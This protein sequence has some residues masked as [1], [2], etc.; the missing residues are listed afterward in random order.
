MVKDAAKPAA[1]GGV[2]KFDIPHRVRAVYGRQL[3]I[4]VKRRSLRLGISHL[5]LNG[6]CG[7]REHYQASIHAGLQ[8]RPG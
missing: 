3:G 2:V 7:R 1:K 5:S 8:P 6:R 4:V